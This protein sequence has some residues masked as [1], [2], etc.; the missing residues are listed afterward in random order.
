MHLSIWVPSAL[1]T[2]D[3]ITGKRK[4]NACDNQQHSVC[5]PAE[6]GAYLY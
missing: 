6:P 4:D 3:R 2:V 1:N 5:L